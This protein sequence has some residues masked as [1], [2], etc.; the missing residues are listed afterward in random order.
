MLSQALSGLACLAFM[1][2]RFPILRMQAAEKRFDLH[3][4]KVLCWMGIPMGLQYSI[5]AVGSIILQSAV[6]G[7]GTAAIASV[8]AGAKLFQ[9]ICCPYDAMGSSMATYCGQNVGACKLDRLGQGMRACAWLG[10]GYAVLAVGAMLLFAPQCAML[11]LNQDEADLARLVSLTSQYITTLTAFFF[12]LALVNIVRFSIQ[13]MGFSQLA[14]LAGVL[15]MAARTVMGQVFVPLFGFT[16]RLLC[17]PGGLDQRRSVPDPRRHPL[18][19]PSAE[20]VSRSDRG[21]RPPPRPRG[22]TVTPLTQRAQAQKRL[23]LSICQK[24]PPVRLFPKCGSPGIGRG[25]VQ[26]EGDQGGEE[27]GLGLYLE[28]TAAGLDKAG[29]NGQAQPAAAVGTALVPPDEA[30]GV[31]QAG[32]EFC[33]RGV[34]QGGHRLSLLHR[35]GQV[36]PGTGQGVFQGVAQQILEHPVE[37]VT[38]PLDEHRVVG[39]LGAQLQPALLDGLVH[40]RQGLAEQAARSSRL[41]L[42]GSWP[43]AALLTSN[44]SCTI[45]F[46]RWAF[47]ERIVTYSP[48]GGSRC[49]CSSSSA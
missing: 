1:V 27:V 34:A 6:N 17:L 7:L 23:G 16:A 24:S 26:G 43:E 49:S 29:G 19:P 20:A 25:G 11:F 5:T 46:S 14:I 10:L 35:E 36:H 42:T 18:H 40:I 22:R 8:A 31:V 44:T 48:A 12:P 37:A 33:G 41:R 39:E 2:R 38:V 47:W 9:L 21:G 45:P 13:G 30:L 3:S 28:L 4:A 32:T 15:E